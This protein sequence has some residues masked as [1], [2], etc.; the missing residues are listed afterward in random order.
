MKINIYL[1][2]IIFFLPII[3]CAQVE[4]KNSQIIKSDLPSDIFFIGQIKAGCK[5][6]DKE[7]VHI[8]LL[9]ETGEFPSKNVRYDN[10]RDAELYAY[11]FIIEKDSI[12]KNWRIYDYVKECPVDMKANFLKNSFKITDLNNDGIGEVWIMYKAD[13]FGDVSPVKMKIIMYQGGQK[14]AMRGRSKVKVADAEFEGGEF[15]FDSSFLNG[16]IEFRDF[17]EELWNNNL[18]EVWD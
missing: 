8:T 10:Y 15:K 5:W 16:P 3:S 12:R 14:F 2:K 18:S 11:D 6:S 4:I 7:G 17:A 13:C 1:L 9:T